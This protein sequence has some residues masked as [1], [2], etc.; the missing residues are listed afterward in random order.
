MFLL[1]TDIASLV[2]HEH[3]R[4]LARMAKVDPNETALAI[5]TRLEMLRGRIDAI[6][7]SATADELLRAVAGFARTEV[8]LSQFRI[9]SIDE[10]AATTFEQ[11]RGNK[12]LKKMDRGDLLQAAIAL[13]NNATLVTRNTKDYA[14][15]PNLKLENW[16]E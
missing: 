7:K 6:V 14:S 12:K 13:A 1:D 2:L 9:I 15:V 11:L 10:K 16:A 5:I 3:E 8:F 4:V